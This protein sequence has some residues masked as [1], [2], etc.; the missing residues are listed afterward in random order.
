MIFR[1]QLAS[2]A[3]A[4]CMVLAPLFSS[5]SLT[6]VWTGAKGSQ[7]W[8]DGGNWQGGTAPASGADVVL[9]A[10]L[11]SGAWITLDA[12]QSLDSLSIAGAMGDYYLYGSAA[13]N[14][15]T[16]GS[17]GLTVAAAAN[18]YYYL[19]A[20]SSLNI[21]V[22][23]PQTWTI[24]TNSDEASGYNTVQM[25]A[26]I[27]GSSSDPLTISV[28]RNGYLSLGGNNTFYA[29]DTVALNNSTLTIASGT[30]LSNATLD[31]SGNTAIT[32][33]SNIDL[34][35]PNAVSIAGG[36]TT[37]NQTLYYIYNVNDS[38]EDIP[39]Y[40][41][42]SL[43]FSGPVTLTGATEIDVNGHAPVVFSGSL[44]ESGGS[45]SITKGGQ[46]ML[47]VTGSVGLTGGVSVD[48]GL[49]IIGSASAVPLTGKVGVY[50][51]AGY[52]G[53]D[54]AGA[55]VSAPQFLS[56]LDS[57]SIGTIGFDAATPG[58]PA[59]VPVTDTINLSGFSSEMGFP[60][61][62][63]AT[64]AVI[65][66]TIIPGSGG[67]QFGG[68]GGT[69][70]VTSALTDGA[71]R[72]NSLNLYS[73][74]GENQSLVLILSGSNSYSGGTTIENSILRFSNQDALGT[75]FSFNFANRGYLGL[76][77]TPAQSDLESLWSSISLNDATAVLGFDSPNPAAQNTVSIS[78]DALQSFPAGAFLGT[79]TDATIAITKGD[80]SMPSI[81][82]AAVR[83]GHLTV[84]P[85]PGGDYSLTLGIPND[86]F[87]A[88]TTNY[89][90]DSSDRGLFASPQ[91]TVEMQGP[92]TYTLGTTLQGGIVL[93][94][95]PAALGTGPISI[96]GGVTLSTVFIDA[97]FDVKNDI[98][99][100]VST[101][102]P[103]LTLANTND[104]TL[105]GRI[106]DG[107]SDNGYGYGTINVGLAGDNDAGT[108]TLAGD[109]SAFY[110]RINVNQGS[111]D[112]AND[113]AVANADLSIE[114]NCFVNFLAAAPQV[115]SLNGDGSVHLGSADNAA[116][117]TING[118]RDNDSYFYGSINGSGGIVVG[119]ADS[120]AP[121][122]VYLSGYNTYSGG[123]VVN[124]SG[125]LIA[126]DTNALGYG[127]VTVSGG[128]LNLRSSSVTLT[129]TLIFGAGTSTIGG[130]GT[131]ASPDGVVIGSSRTGSQIVAPGISPTN[132]NYFLADNLSTAIGTLSFGTNLT[133]ASGGTY[134]WMLGDASG[135]SGG[136]YDNIYVNGTL[137]ISSSSEAPFTLALFQTGGDTRYS[138]PVS[139]DNSQ[140][141]SW[142][143]VSTSGGIQGF[144][145]GAFSIDPSGFTS[146]FG[147]GAFS[148]SLGS[149][150]D[151]L[152]LNFTP[153]PEPSTYALMGLGL[154]VAL[155]GMRCRKRTAA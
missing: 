113:N 12:S 52:L 69:L 144:D 123:T 128:S 155:V 146:D 135:V 97:T 64:N 70:R 82:F 84:A 34:V 66:G 77:Y 41:P 150:S 119:G 148:L 147:G 120:A 109:N 54:L 122:N 117:L 90:Y 98:S 137:T 76:D 80:S 73:P 37:L 74:E 2:T 79:S 99:L 72:S 22:S 35:L 125:T 1:R 39:W 86:S 100:P 11:Y 108:L 55:G 30:A 43:T 10:P 81:G 63:T 51:D 154:G 131:F 65:N 78:T 50:G 140:S 68:G 59:V 91:G 36:V 149:D 118:N 6:S 111:L 115:A 133:F 29:T 112:V 93:L 26:N 121:A 20:S 136:G 3:V 152:L 14:T 16:L 145:A 45:Q 61:L 151:S 134:Q 116:T 60:R 83:G 58:E 27:T 19:Y 31:I 48:D 38:S 106:S 96:V 124:K 89:A 25:Y 153:V 67:Y 7:Q 94:D 28:G 47:V 129:N 114:G 75:N 101:W 40:S 139:F 110:G 138:G 49:M 143:I 46:G 15:L 57:S 107:D 142:T 71:D 24:G 130:L 105:S 88:A 13:S 33:N 8:S 102:G 132:S 126:D 53:V 103:T 56:R 92:N 5:E 104:F 18:H 9:N 17:G 141:Y 32:N 62:G 95:N 127:S 21:S 42:N 4:F 23:A 85:L 87:Q 44:V